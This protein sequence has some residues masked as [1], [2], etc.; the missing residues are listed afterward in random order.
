[1]N[2][3]SAAFQAE[4]SGTAASRAWSTE[5]FQLSPKN[6]SRQIYRMSNH[7]ETR[8]K[9]R[10][11]KRSSLHSLMDCAN[12]EVPVGGGC[13]AIR[14]AREQHFDPDLRGAIDHIKDVTL[15]VDECTGA[16]V[17]VLHDHG[18][19]KGRIYRKAAR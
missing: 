4:G 15:I 6:A 3:R 5:A 11:V 19:A 9:Q 2:S 13:I 18:T 14:L 8:A 7:A 12:F 16:V 1:M 17:T 10:G